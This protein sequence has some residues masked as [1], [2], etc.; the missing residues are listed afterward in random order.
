MPPSRY[1]DAIIC[2]TCGEV[3]IRLDDGVTQSR[4]DQAACDHERARHAIPLP[5][6]TP[7]EAP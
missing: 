6:D 4:A 1:R 3:V 2:T 7:R 5:H